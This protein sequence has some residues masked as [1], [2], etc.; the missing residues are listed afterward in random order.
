MTNYEMRLFNTKQGAEVKKLLDSMSMDKCLYGRQ[1]ESIVAIVE[2]D[3]D[4]IEEVAN[5]KKITYVILKDSIA[6]FIN[7]D[8]FEYKE[9]ETNDKIFRL[10]SL[11]TF[12]ERLLS[13]NIEALIIYELLTDYKDCDMEENFKRL[14]S[15][16]SNYFNWENLYKHVTSAV[17]GLAGKH[18][19]K[20]NE[21]KYNAVSFI[22]EALALCDAMNS[23]YGD[24]RIFT[25]S[26]HHYKMVMLTEKYEYQKDLEKFVL[27]ELDNF[28]NELKNNKHRNE[29]KDSEY[30]KALEWQYKFKMLQ[31]YFFA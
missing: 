12:V 24:N 26:L 29:F 15:Q 22:V 19:V 27:A 20:S 1:I 7:R 23:T 31:D 18:D 5:R 14:L 30:R 2:K 17:T 4:T 11:T 8:N 16:F 6:S 9:I 28:E 25:R 10:F 3:Y 13:H 21:A